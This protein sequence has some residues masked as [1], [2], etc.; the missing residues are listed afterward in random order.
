VSSDSKISYLVDRFYAESHIDLIGLW[1]LVA[2]VQQD[3]ALDID[4]Q[5]RVFWII[6]AL[7]EKGL[8]V[9]DPPYATEGYRPWPDQ[10]PAVV[11]ERIRR[12]WEALGRLPNIPDIAW[13]KL[14]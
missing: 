6:T 8:Q 4:I 2:A 11:I 5:T 10:D 14:V 3:G 1:Q 12:E 13:F 9:G 7:L